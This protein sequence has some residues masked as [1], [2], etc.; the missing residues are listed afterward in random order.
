MLCSFCEKRVVVAKGL[1]SACYYRQKRTGSLEYTRKGRVTYC[2][3]EGCGEVAHAKKLCFMHYNRQ[4]KHG[5]TNDTR[6]ANWGEKHAHPLAEQWNYLHHKKGVE[7]CAPEWRTDFERFVADVGERPSPKHRLKPRDRSRL[8]GPD[9]FVWVA[10]EYERQPG[11]TVRDAENR[12]ERGR[13]KSDPDKFRNLHL[14]KKY[15]G[16]TLAGVT[17]ISEAQNHRCAI[18]GEEEGVE[19]KGVKISLA[20]DHDHDTGDVRGLLCVKCNRGLGLFRDRPDLLTTAISYLRD[21]PAFKLPIPR[22]APR[23]TT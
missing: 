11:E 7:L 23:T 21:P 1:C 6:P 16:L 20:V 15:A 13:R 18:C 19:I 5:H 12:A 2:E 3:V 8:I 10:P 14:R 22:R 17:L 9:N 4:R